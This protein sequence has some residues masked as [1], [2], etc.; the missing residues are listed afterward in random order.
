VNREPEQAESRLSRLA[1]SSVIPRVPHKSEA[2]KNVVEG[3]EAIGL[4]AKKGFWNCCDAASRGVLACWH[5]V[6][7]IHF[8]LQS[9][10]KAIY[11]KLGIYHCPQS[12]VHNSQLVRSDNPPLPPNLRG[13]HSYSQYVCRYWLQCSQVNMQKHRPPPTLKAWWRGPALD[14]P[15]MQQPVNHESSCAIWLR[16]CQ[17]LLEPPSRS[18]DSS[19]PSQYGILRKQSA[20]V[21]NFKAAEKGI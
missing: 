15:G 13:V 8:M 18:L 21:S 3:A 7:G 14:R 12:T 11:P 2:K 20:L 4:Y 10:C 6:H 17:P 9:N 1:N 5:A 19:L 16:S